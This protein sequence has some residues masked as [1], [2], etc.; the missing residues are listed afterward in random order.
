MDRIDSA[1]RYLR[2]SE[3]LSADQHQ[4]QLHKLYDKEHYVEMVLCSNLEP[5]TE[6][7]S[8]GIVKRRLEVVFCDEERKYC[9]LET[10]YNPDGSLLDTDKGFTYRRI[11][12]HKTIGYYKKSE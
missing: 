11:Y 10:N 1:D 12:H 5:R 9:I 6:Y 8:S 3:A 4:P 7:Y 2:E